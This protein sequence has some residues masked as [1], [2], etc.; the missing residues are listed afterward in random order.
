LPNNNP[1]PISGKAGAVDHFAHDKPNAREIYLTGVLF[2]PSGELADRRRVNQLA[3]VPDNVMLCGLLLA[4]SVIDRVPVLRPVLVG[5]NLTPIVQLDPAAKLLVLVQLVVAAL[6]EN[7]LDAVKPLS[8]RWAG[9]FFGLVTVMLFAVLVVL[10]TTEPKLSE[11]GEMAGADGR[12]A[13]VGVAVGVG[14][15]VGEGVGEGDG[16]GEGV[17]EGVGDGVGVA[18][19][20]GVGVEEETGKALTKLVASAEPHPVD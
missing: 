17:R 12:V 4:L 2:C 20:V 16:V 1:D 8:T 5:A 19:G 10:I 14:E 18:V 15:R 13:G 7:W 6:I 9:L 3:P 11:D